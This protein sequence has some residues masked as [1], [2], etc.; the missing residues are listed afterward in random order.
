MRTLTTKKFDSLRI[1]KKNLY[2]FVFH[3]EF[4]FREM[5]LADRPGILVQKHFEKDRMKHELFSQFSRHIK[6]LKKNHTPFLPHYTVVFFPLAFP[7]LTSP[8]VIF[9]EK[10]QTNCSKLEKKNATEERLSEMRLHGEKDVTLKQFII[11]EQC[12]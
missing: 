2:C 10:K 1:Y 12:K 6:Q 9:S 7:V 11:T 8:S 3:F 5:L 4:L